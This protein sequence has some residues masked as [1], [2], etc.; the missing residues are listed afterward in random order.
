MPEP[1]S[2][3]LLKQYQ[4]GQ[5]E[6]ATE[7]FDRYVDRLI[8]LAQ[9]RLGTKLRRRVDADDVVQSAYR[10]FFVRAR[11]G[12]YQLS[13]PGDLW[14]LLAR[15][16]LNKLYGQVE[17]QTAGKR[18]VDRE[19]R[20]QHQLAHLGSRNPTVAEVVA[21][22]E[23][24]S[25]IL[26][27]LSSDEHAALLLTLQGQPNEEIS[28]SI[29]K[30]ER[31][32]RRLLA[33]ARRHLEQRLL[34]DEIPGN[35]RSACEFNIPDQQAPLRFDDF[36]IEKLLGTGGMGKV[37]RATDK[38]SEKSV[39]IKSLHKAL[40]GDERAVRR[41]IQESQILSQLKHP[42][43]VGV[44]GLGRFPG[45]GFYI[46]MEFIDG[47]NLQSRL[48]DGP[49][50]IAEAIS[51]V[52][53][54]AAAVQ[55]AHEQGIVHCDLKPGNILVDQQSRVVVTDFGFAFVVTGNTKSQWNSIGGTAGYLAP[56]ILRGQSEPTP[57]ADI[58]SLGVL[59]WN[60]ISAELPQDGELANVNTPLL[61]SIAPISRRC[62]AREP[63]DRFPRVAEFVS[64]LEDI[65]IQ[66]IDVV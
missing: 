54:T 33:Q 30:S 66:N 65:D 60:L 26:D 57:A 47:T 16:T 62:L 13:R 8:A 20:D 7:I 38:R 21:V 46:V 31:T 50:P 49:L 63:G 4:A 14:R 41:F 37:Y 3:E 43:I 6:A 24:L 55:Y 12:Q 39:A 61:E 23:Q 58:F 9:S 52:K 29:G 51:F 11:E 45:G 44:D 42:H 34:A 2:Q 25:L 27:E 35:R 22:G 18:T 40:Q 56:E 64:A 32:V 48:M 10:S 19:D 36:V 1:S 17:R 28:K 15:T 5:T 53:Q 59:L